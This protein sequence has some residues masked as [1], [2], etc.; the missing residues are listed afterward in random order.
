MC[1]DV[2]IGAS[3]VLH[4]MC[5]PINGTCVATCSSLSPCLRRFVPRTCSLTPVWRLTSCL[6][7]LQLYSILLLQLLPSD[8]FLILHLCTLLPVFQACRKRVG[9]SSTHIHMSV[10]YTS[11]FTSSLITIP[12]RVFSIVRTLFSQHH[13][14]GTCHTSSCIAPL[15]SSFLWVHGVRSF[16]WAARQGVPRRVHCAVWSCLTFLLNFN[17]SRF[18]GYLCL[19]KVFLGDLHTGAEKCERGVLL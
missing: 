4:A 12:S 9:H 16:M 17:S 2:A 5:A 11:L 19:S 14:A 13:A 15:W 1:G 8:G 10:V 18:F 7:L 3:T 6:V